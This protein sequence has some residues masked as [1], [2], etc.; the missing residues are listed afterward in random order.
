MNAIM[1]TRPA[2]HMLPRPSCWLLS[3]LALVSASS[4]SNLGWTDCSGTAPD[5]GS[6]Q[7]AWR[8]LSMHYHPDKTKGDEQ[9]C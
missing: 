5:G 8:R 3:W 4:M 9:G 6:I 1:R 7:R 2:L